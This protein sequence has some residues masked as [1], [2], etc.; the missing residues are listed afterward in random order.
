MT[1]L[2]FICLLIYAVRCAILNILL[3]KAAEEDYGVLR[4]SETP[5]YIARIW[6]WV[7]VALFSALKI[8]LFDGAGSGACIGRWC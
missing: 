4:P 5:N 2:F 3:E 6:G 1:T 7:A 8:G